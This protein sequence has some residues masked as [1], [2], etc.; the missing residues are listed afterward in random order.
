MPLYTF[1]CSGKCQR[2]VTLIRRMDD[3]DV[4]AC[5]ECGA[6]GKKWVRQLSRFNVGGCAQ[7]KTF[8]EASDQNL[9]RVGEEGI[10]R[11]QEEK[12]KLLGGAGFNPKNLPKGAKLMRESAGPHAEPLFEPLDKRL[13][14]GSK[15]KVNHYIET[16]EIK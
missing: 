16:G 1:L 8:G 14:L 6:K 9:E 2:E 11:M 3:R 13:D 10:K 15:E 4:K 12:R 7:P 5:P